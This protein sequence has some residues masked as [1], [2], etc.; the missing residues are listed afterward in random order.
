MHNGCR[1]SSVVVFNLSSH[2]E[3]EVTVGQLADGLSQSAVKPL[4]KSNC[5]GRSMRSS[6][7]AHQSEAEP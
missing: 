3:N 5:L 2:Q 4:N 1:G 7:K 6:F